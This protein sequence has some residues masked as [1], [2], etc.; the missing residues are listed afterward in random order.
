MPCRLLIGK[1]NLDR[2]LLRE[3][4]CLYR[5]YLQKSKDVL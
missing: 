4:V 2:G 3:R 1:N 5:Q